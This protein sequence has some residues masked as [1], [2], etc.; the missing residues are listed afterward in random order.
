MRE[1]L[2]A[3]R[4]EELRWR[5]NLD[6][7]DVQRH[8]DLADEPDEL[9]FQ[10]RRALVVYRQQVLPHLALER[11]RVLPAVL[12]QGDTASDLIRIMAEELSAVVGRIDAAQADLLQD[13]TSSAA[14][15]RAVG[16]LSAAAVLATVAMR[17]RSEVLLPLASRKDTKR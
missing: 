11:E 10:L 3:L 5:A 15:S 4:N 17:F 9:L 12:G 8:A 6:L 7:T 2:D 1:S 14:R 13:P 16:V